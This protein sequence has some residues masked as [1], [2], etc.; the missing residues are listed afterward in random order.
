MNSIVPSGGATRARTLPQFATEVAALLHA[1]GYRPEDARRL[2]LRHVRDVKRAW[3]GGQPPCAASDQILRE[4]RKGAIYRLTGRRDPRRRKRTLTRKR[5]TRR[6]PASTVT[7]NTGETRAIE[8]IYEDG[9]YNCPFCNYA[10]FPPPR[11]TGRCENPACSMNISAARAHEMKAAHEAR[12]REEADRKRNHEYAMKRIAEERSAREQHTHDVIAE[13]RSR[14]ACVDCALKSIRYY[15]SKPKFTKHRGACPLKRRDP[16]LSHRA[17]ADQAAYAERVKSQLA[18]RYGAR[19]ALAMM[20]I[21]GHVVTYGFRAGASPH[22]TADWI[23]ARRGKTMRDPTRRNLH[24]K[25]DQREKD[26][27]FDVYD[28]HHND[29]WGGRAPSA[30]EAR[31]RIRMKFPHAHVESCTKQCHVMHDPSRRRRSKKFERCV[32][33]VKR[34]GGRVNPWAVCNASLKRRRD[35]MNEREWD[36]EELILYADN[37]HDLYKQ[38]RPFLANAYRK[39][40]KGTYSPELAVKLWMYYVDRAAKK[41]AKDFGGTWNKLFPKPVRE[42]AARYLAVREARMLHNGEYNGFPRLG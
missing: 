41:Y 14:G 35:P 7:D 3:T 27:V 25:I 23:G 16:T 37:D 19:R 12:Q 8:K 21:D 33:A 42:K 18:H 26:F 22:K 20:Q 9:S 39:M 30:E 29:V 13:A 34:R 5:R 2:T 31:E 11:G 15:G 24:A 28:H 10:V 6:D 38:K 36:E 32:R 4:E 40:K 17:A 1:K